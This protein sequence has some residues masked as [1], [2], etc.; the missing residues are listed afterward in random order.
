M[1]MPKKEWSDDPLYLSILLRGNGLDHI[2]KDLKI[3]GVI[4]L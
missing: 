4:A 2:L 1:G 3:F